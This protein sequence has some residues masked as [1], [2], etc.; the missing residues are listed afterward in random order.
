MANPKFKHPG[1]VKQEEFLTKMFSAPLYCPSC[2]GQH[3]YMELTSHDLAIWEKPEL[4]GVEG[5]FGQC[6]IAI[7]CPVTRRQIVR[8][9]K[10]DLFGSRWELVEIPEDFNP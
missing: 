2:K 7:F 9:D 10:G 1:L 8:L 6:K 4:K 5:P 3:S